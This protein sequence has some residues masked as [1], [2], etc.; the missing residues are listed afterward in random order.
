MSIFNIPARSLQQIVL[1]IVG[2]SEN[3]FGEWVGHVQCRFLLSVSQA[4]IGAMLQLLMIVTKIHII[5]YSF[6][7]EGT[8][9]EEH[10]ADIV[11]ALD[12]SLV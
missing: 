12:G 3:G 2:A 1:L 9:L 6:G 8:N 5:L 10:Y 11:L 4:W 7:C